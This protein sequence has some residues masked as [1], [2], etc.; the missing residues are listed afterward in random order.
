M[1]K[2][3][4]LSI[5]IAILTLFSSTYYFALSLV[6]TYSPNQVA[7]HNSPDNCWMIFEEKVYDV[8]AEIE[9]HE[10]MLDI[11]EW[12]GKDMTEDFKSKAGRDRNHNPSTYQLLN[13]YYI[14]ELETKEATNTT[15]TEITPSSRY[16]LWIPL[17]GTF[18][19]YWL[20]YFY[21]RKNKS[22]KGYSV[23][24]HKTIF[25]SIML[26]ALIPAM[27]FGL[28]MVLRYSYP[29]LY[30]INFDFLFWHVEGSIIFTALAISHFIERSAQYRAQ[31][32]VTAKNI[33]N[34][35]GK[36]D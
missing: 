1:K 2:I 10:S 4:T 9:N 17:L 35:K 25:N 21:S 31:A 15:A 34:K 23:I 12:C 32:K 33:L 20:S 28:F 36:I 13:Q 11:R 18:L 27:G 5:T 6:P 29:E 16:S 14:G 7:Q 22:Q 30:Q 3:I 8:T 19:L 24:T 26:I